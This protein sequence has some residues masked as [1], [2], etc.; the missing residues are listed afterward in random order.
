MLVMRL[1]LVKFAQNLYRPVDW[2]VAVHLK[3]QGEVQSLMG[4]VA[5]LVFV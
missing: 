4:Q 5:V 3:V 2:L 1:V